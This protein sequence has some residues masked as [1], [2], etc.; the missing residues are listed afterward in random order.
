MTDCEHIDDA[1]AYVLGALPDDEVEPFVAHLATCADLPARGRRAARWPSTRCPLAAPPAA[2]PP[3]LRGRI[4]A[5][6]NAE[7]ELLAAAGPEA[8]R[9]P[10]PGAARRAG[11]RERSAGP[12]SRCAPPSPRSPRASSSPS[13]SPVRSWPPAATAPGPCPPR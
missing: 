8:D 1:A 13:A 3:E 5:V 4:M 6:V 10:P 12:A 9:P 7:A 2:P 11:L